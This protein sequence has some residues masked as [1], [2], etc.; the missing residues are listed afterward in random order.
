MYQ[1]YFILEWYSTCFGQ[2]FRPSS[3]VQDC[4]YSNRHLSNRYCC[5]RASKQTA[6]SVFTYALLLYV[7]SWT[8]DDGKKD[9]P[10]HVECHSKIKLILLWNDT[11]HVSDGLYIHHQ[12][13]KTVHTAV[14]QMLLFDICLLLYVESWNADDRRKD[15]PKHVEFTPIK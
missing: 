14:K 15:R 4:A 7:Q 2:F 10:K 12:Q 5:L 3:A 11:L 8:A 6:V 9:R 13:F 1:I